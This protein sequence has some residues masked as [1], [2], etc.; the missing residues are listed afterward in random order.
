MLLTII[1][2]LGCGSAPPDPT[3]QTLLIDGVAIEDKI[4][5]LELALKHRPEAASAEKLKALE[6]KLSGLEDRLTS[7]EQI[8]RQLQNEGLMKSELVIFDPRETTL[9]GTN[10]QTI[11]NQLANKVS[12]LEHAVY[13]ERGDAGPGLF[14][15]RDNRKG[16]P[17]Q[18]GQPGKGQHGGP[19]PNGAEKQMRPPP[20]SNGPPGKP[21][22]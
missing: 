16:Q 13:D 4:Q 19:G 5:S 20:G 6:Q 22:Q 21:P 1:W 3:P 7:A 10:V 14:E 2:A 8:L 17:G 11:L 15:L 9:E 18:Q 12:K